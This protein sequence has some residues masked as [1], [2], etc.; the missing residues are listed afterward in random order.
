MVR[1]DDPDLISLSRIGDIPAFETLVRRYEKRV[2]VVAGRIVGNPQD[3]R[4][5][6]QKVFI[7]VYRYLDQFR[8]DRNFFTWL[9]RIIVNASF[10]FLKREKRFRAVPLDDV[11]ADHIPAA[12]S[13]TADEK[14]FQQQVLL[15][16]DTLSPTNLRKAP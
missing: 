12:N 4:D 9:Y 14:M 5:V 16:L 6:T 13:D 3:A 2:M 1:L 7:R 15:W 10:D 8:N 11:A